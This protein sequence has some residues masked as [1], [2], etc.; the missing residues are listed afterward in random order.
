MSLDKSWLD[1]QY[2]KDG[3]IKKPE[4]LE[5]EMTDPPN[6]IDYS[7]IL[8]LIYGSM[9]GMALGDALGASVEFRPH[10]YLAA[11]P[12]TTMKGGGTW[13]LNKGQVSSSHINVLP[14]FN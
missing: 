5:K 7:D 8:D 4:E 13:G 6:D 12:V 10:D 9:I 1:P 3:T 11:N 14:F 2:C